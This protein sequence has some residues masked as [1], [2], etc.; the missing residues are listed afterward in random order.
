MAVWIAE[1]DHLLPPGKVV[2]LTNNTSFGDVLPMILLVLSL[3]IK[4]FIVVAI[5]GTALFVS[6]IIM[7]YIP[8]GRIKKFLLTNDSK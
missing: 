3:V 8:D 7:R 2:E 5:F 6:K 1:L 4:P